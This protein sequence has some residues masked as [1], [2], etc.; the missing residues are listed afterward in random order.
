[1]SRSRSNAK[2]ASSSCNSPILT[3]RM[4]F[5]L[6]DEHGKRKAPC[7]CRKPRRRP[8]RPLRR[9]AA[10]SSRG[11]L[12][13]ELEHIIPEIDGNSHDLGI[14]GLALHSYLIE[15]RDLA[16][17]GRAPGGPEIHHQRPATEARELR[18]LAVAIRQRD[19]G[20]RVGDRFLR[21]S[22]SARGG[23]RLQP[24]AGAAGDQRSGAG[25]FER[26]AKKP[27]APAATTTSTA[28]SR[29]GV[30]EPDDFTVRVEPPER[31]LAGP[32]PRTPQPS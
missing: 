22:A 13:G 26:Y 31:P 3:V 12:C 1:M 11:T 7:P 27:T 19:V 18:G 20:Q 2:L 25:C 17:A 5:W 6:S 28:P 9:S 21:R 29:R 23:R 32:R 8:S 30:E 14:L 15:Q 4:R 16:A 24:A 10:G